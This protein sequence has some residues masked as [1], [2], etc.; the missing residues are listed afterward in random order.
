MPVDGV[1]NG[2]RIQPVNA[3]HWLNISVGVWKPSVFLGRSFNC[4]AMA[5]SLICE[6]SETSTPLGRY[7]KAVLRH[8]P[9]L[10]ASYRCVIVCRRRNLGDYSTLVAEGEGIVSPNLIRMISPP[11]LVTSLPGRTWHSSSPSTSKWNLP[12]SLRLARIAVNREALGDEVPG[13][14]PLP[15]LHDQHHFLF[16]CRLRES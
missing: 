3:T 5:L 10:A 11:S 14:A 4:L 13:H 12:R 2:W 16:D 8:R 1:P 6:S 9:L 15:V 7:P